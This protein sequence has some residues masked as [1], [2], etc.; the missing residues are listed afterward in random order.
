MTPGRE[1]MYQAMLNK[2][3]SYEGIFFAGITTTGIFCRPVCHARKPKAEHVEYFSTVREALLAGYRPCKKCRPLETAAKAPPEI[4]RLLEDVETHELY[5]LRDQDLR[6]RGLD[7]AGVRRWFNKYHGMTFQA[8][9]RSL[10][11]GKAFGRLR[12]GDTVLETAYNTGYKSVSGFTGAFQ[13]QM[14]VNPSG[15]ADAGVIFIMQLSTPLG[16]MIS[17]ATE[18]GLCLLEFLDRRMLETE[19]ALIRKLYRAELVQGSNDHMIQIREEMTRYFDGRLKAFKTPLDIRGTHFQRKVWSQLM[20]IPYGTTR[21]YTEQAEAVGDTKA[22]RAVARA[23]GDNRIAIVIPCHRVI[24]ADGRLT[25]YGGGLWRKKYLLDLE[26]KNR[27][28]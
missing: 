8:F 26:R 1:E 25:G 24:G 9:L 3:K 4:Q 16:P 23:N 5:R 18:N 12:D 7:P 17:G 14:K 6:D 21:S 19:S 11:V 27:R 2:D 20:T 13:K 15:N 22:V 28:D 10:R